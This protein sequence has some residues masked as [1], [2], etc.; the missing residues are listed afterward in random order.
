M[1]KTTGSGEQPGSADR[2][3]THRMIV[4]DLTSILV[5]IRKSLKLIESEIASEPAFDKGFVGDIV[6]LDDL[7][8]G[9]AR[10]CS[11][12]QECDAGLNAALGLLQE[13]MIP[14]HLRRDFIAADGLSARGIPNGGDPPH[15]DRSP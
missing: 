12:L 3:E 8:P 15:S 4:S 10:A 13:S 14:R 6:V 2:D 1:Q 9:Y 7:A 11:V 5:Q